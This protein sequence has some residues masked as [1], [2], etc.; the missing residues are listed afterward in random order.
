M[1]GGFVL[2]FFV[3]GRWAIAAATRTAS[4][5]HASS[6]MA[7]FRRMVFLI[8]NPNGKGHRQVCAADAGSAVTSAV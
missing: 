3:P 4:P 8:I 5:K 7:G 6:V 2:D 1:G